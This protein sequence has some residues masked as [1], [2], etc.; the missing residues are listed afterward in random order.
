MFS[1][2]SLGILWSCG[3]AVS[4]LCWEPKGSRF[5]PHHGHP[6]LGDIHW[7]TCEVIIEKS[8]IRRFR[9]PKRLAQCPLLE[10]INRV[11]PSQLMQ[12]RHVKY[13]LL[14]WWALRDWNS[15]LFSIFLY[16]FCTLLYKW[17]F[18]YTFSWEAMNKQC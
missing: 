14:C 5:K 9:E 18:S 10:R 1:V 15:L 7:S 13:S 2:G 8:V 12:N 3:L 4:E 6:C 17:N 16:L 11:Y